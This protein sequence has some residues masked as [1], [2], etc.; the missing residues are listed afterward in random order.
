MELLDEHEQGEIVRKWLR[1]NGTAIVGGI[2]LGL[3]LIFGYQWWVRS[4]IEHSLTAATQYTVIADAVAQ[5]D[6][7]A[8][9]KISAELADNYSDTPYAS[10]ALMQLAQQQYDA[11]QA[12]AALATLERAAKFS[13]DAQMRGLITLRSARL[14]LASGDADGAISL[15]AGDGVAHFPAM[16]AEI[17]GD[18]LLS[19]G[20]ANAARKA[21]AEAL[22]TL[23]ASA[24]NRRIV[25]MKLADLGGDPE[26]AGA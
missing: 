15:L 7:D 13:Q 26:A 25:E 22:T 2:G 16:S 5:K 17:R 19:K 6:R 23:D 1:E 24:P 8:L 20:D 4:K 21:Y 18:A 10:F 9:E 14:H 3:I 12:D 11:G